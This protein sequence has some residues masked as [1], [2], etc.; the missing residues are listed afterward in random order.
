[1]EAFDKYLKQ[2][3]HYSTKVFEEIRPFLSVKNIGEGEYFLRDGKICREIGFVEKGLLRLYY[4]NDGK[5][6][7]NCF[8]KENTI[9]TSYHSLITQKKT[10]TAIQA[11]EPTKLI[12]FS[13]RSLQKLYEKNLFWQQLGRLAAESEYITTECHNRFLRD[14]SATDRYKQILEQDAELL[15]RVPLN[16]LATY[17][18]I[19]PETLSRIR[20]KISQT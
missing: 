9:T 12:V 14:L 17:L 8:C 6:I 2:F 3:P 4:L 13:Y 1:M 18:Q 5:E 7:T 16:Y 20:K 19:A 15:Q 10:D 11:I